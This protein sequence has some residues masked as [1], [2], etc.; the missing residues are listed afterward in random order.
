MQTLGPPSAPV[1]QN[2]HLTR[3]RVN[4]VHLN[5]G[6]ALV[7]GDVLGDGRKERTGKR[8]HSVVLLQRAQGAFQKSAEMPCWGEKQD[9]K[10]PRGRN[11]ENNSTR[12]L[13]VLLFLNVAWMLKH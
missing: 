5:I 13:K 1:N 3:S 7:L 2:R 12:N 9:R 6:E 4:H 10:Q 8:T 11:R